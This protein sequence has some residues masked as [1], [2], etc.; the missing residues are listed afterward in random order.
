M[1]SNRMDDAKARGA[2][3]RF[4]VDGAV[5]GYAGETVAGALSAGERAHFRR[6]PTRGQPGRYHC[7]MGVC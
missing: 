1:S 5:D 2:P 4:T 7:A 3:I 6:T